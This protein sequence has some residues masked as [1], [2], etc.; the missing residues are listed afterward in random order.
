[1]P[2]KVA[3]LVRVVQGLS[4]HSVEA[5][6]GLVGPGQSGCGGKN[7]S[8]ADFCVSKGSSVVDLR[9][10]QELAGRSGVRTK[11]KGLLLLDH[12]QPQLEPQRIRSGQCGHIAWTYSR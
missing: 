10:Y 11:A 2:K 6:I 5:E 12:Y 1:M 9:G 8:H 3:S 4:L 7:C